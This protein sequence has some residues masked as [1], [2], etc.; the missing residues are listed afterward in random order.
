M[1]PLGIDVAK[2]GTVPVNKY[3]LN[4]GGRFF[5]LVTREASISHNAKVKA[6][7][8]C[9]NIH[10]EWGTLVGLSINTTF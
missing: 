4:G 5:P 2:L 6:L 7:C 8:G 9:Y 3:E 10:G 1:T